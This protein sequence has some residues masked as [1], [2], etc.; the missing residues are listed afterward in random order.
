VYRVGGVMGELKN[1]VT[2]VPALVCD[3]S[4]TSESGISDSESIVE[5]GDVE[6]VEGLLCHIS[7][8]VAAAVNVNGRAG[9]V[10]MCRVL[11]NKHI[12]LSIGGADWVP[13]G[14]VHCRDFGVA[15]YVSPSEISSA[16]G[17]VTVIGRGFS[18]DL[19]R[20]CAVGRSEYVAVY[21]NDTA[22]SC[23]LTAISPMT[24]GVAV[25]GGNSVPLRIVEMNVISSIQPSVLVR[26]EKTMLIDMF[27]F[28]SASNRFS[29][30]V[31]CIL[32]EFISIQGIRCSVVPNV[33]SSVLEFS[34]FNNHAF[35]SSISLPVH[36]VT[37][38][39][40]STRLTF[41][42]GKFDMFIESDVPVSEIS[43]LLCGISSVCSLNSD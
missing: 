32:V 24:V 19:S 26:S 41:R 18:A 38:K 20:S 33:T 4:F 27:G 9:C 39:P 30:S 36:S 42:G 7:G 29:C 8:S 13:A 35:F 17:H 14:V 25:G 16:G 12:A 22:V 1:A 37:L 23:I 6:F 28:F 15:M 40:L 11:G 21:L 3:P 2:L 5:V 43:T 34:I 31:P 10:V